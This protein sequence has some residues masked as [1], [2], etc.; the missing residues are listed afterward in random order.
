[1]NYTGCWIKCF[2]FELSIAKIAVGLVALWLVAWTPY[3][4]VALMGV[5]GHHHFLTPGVTMLPALFAK[6]SACINPFI[7]ISHLI[8]FK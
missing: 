4:V 7:V 3:A 8:A 5:S 6:L 2:Y 1:M